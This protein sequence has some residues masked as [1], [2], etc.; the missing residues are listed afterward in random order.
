[1]TK[2]KQTQFV[3]E[4]ISAVGKKIINSVKLLPES[5]EGM[6]FRQYIADS[7]SNVTMGFKQRNPKRYRKY[8]EEFLNIP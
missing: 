6:E 7:F 2:E 3:E 4:L 8:Y 5:W 1:M